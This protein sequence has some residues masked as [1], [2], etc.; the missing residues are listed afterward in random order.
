VVVPIDLFQWGDLDRASVVV[1]AARVQVRWRP[2]QDVLETC[3]RQA[4]GSG[5]TYEAVGL[6]SGLPPVG[7]T[8]LEQVMPLGYGDEVWERV[9]RALL[10]WDLHRRA[11]ML[12]AVD[13]VGVAVGATVVNAAPCGPWAVLAPCRVVALVEQRDR[14]GFAYGSLP[15]H[16]LA[17]EERFTVERADGVVLLR[18]RSVSRPVGLAGWVPALARA[19]QRH[20][21][22]R[23]AA[24]A[25][26]L[27]AREG[28]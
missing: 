24:A 5:L 1:H 13:V 19:G 4:K 26:R 11:G 2:T 3:L 8:L 10:G 6:S 7:W 22:R 14:C 12:L 21:N 9:G 20:V 25:C 17:G 28:S 23:Y 27:V 16:P 15:G 18:I